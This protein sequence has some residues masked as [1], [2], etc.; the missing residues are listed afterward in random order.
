MA[1][2][3]QKYADVTL[4]TPPSG[5]SDGHLQLMDVQLVEYASLDKGK[6]VE[7]ATSC[8]KGASDL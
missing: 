2:V 8:S 3:Q 7:V 4:K 1:Y 6:L 5:L